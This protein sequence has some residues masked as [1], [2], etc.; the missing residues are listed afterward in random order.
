M[1][2]LTVI[3]PCYNEEETIKYFY[4]ETKKYLDKM[5]ADYEIIFVNDGSKDKTIEEC[6]KVKAVDNKYLST[7]ISSN[8][9]IVDKELLVW[10]VD[11]TK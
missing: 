4:Q 8:L 11:N 2:L 5:D 3:T 10:I 7:S 9:S 6:L 1:P